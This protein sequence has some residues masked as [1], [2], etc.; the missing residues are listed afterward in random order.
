MQIVLYKIRLEDEMT[1]SA[2]VF[3]EYVVPVNGVDQIKANY[4][5]EDYF[6]F[7]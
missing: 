7:D 1:R 5:S 2:D 6:L 3:T 4:K